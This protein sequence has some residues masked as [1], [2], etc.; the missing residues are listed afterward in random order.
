MMTNVEAQL[1]KQN[2]IYSIYICS[3]I[4][5]SSALP[6]PSAP[7]YRFGTAN[8]EKGRG[9][10]LPLEVATSEKKNCV[11]CFLTS[12]QEKK[13]HQTLRGM[14]K[15]CWICLCTWRSLSLSRACSWI[16]HHAYPTSPVHTSHLYAWHL[17]PKNH[18]HSAFIIGKISADCCNITSL[19]STWQW[20]SDPW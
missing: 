11:S 2:L 13:K 7:V 8:A 15:I 18:G 10:Y 9:E 3:H 16:V 19:V 4:K 12:L 17:S 1:C 20:R 14:L 5:P 6:L